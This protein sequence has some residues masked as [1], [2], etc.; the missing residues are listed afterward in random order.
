LLLG[1]LRLRRSFVWRNGRTTLLPTSDGSSPPWGDPNM[2]DGAWA[3]GN[4]YV[5]LPNGHAT[6]HAVLWRRR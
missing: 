5:K 4:E 3:I 6:A 1:Q 2:V